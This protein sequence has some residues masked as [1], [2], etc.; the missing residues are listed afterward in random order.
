LIGRADWNDCLNLN[1]FS[2]D[3]DESFQT[4]PLRTRG[5]TAESVFLAGM[6]VMVG[7]EYARLCHKLGEV[8]EA[9]AI[10][11]AVAKMREAIDT[12]GFDGEWFLRAYDARGKKVGSKE[13]P[14]GKIFVEPQGF[15]VMAGMGIEDGK[16]RKA[17]DA[18]YRYL[19]TL[20]GIK[21]LFPAYTSYHEELGEISSYPP[22]YK[23][24]AGIF[25][26]NNPW[27]MIAEV[28]LG[29]GDR[30]FE[31]YRKICPSF[32]EEM[33]ELH[34]LEPYVYAQVIA[35]DDSPRFGEA[36]NSWLTGAAA[37]N[38]VAF[39]QYILG[40]RPD[41]DGLCIDPCL[42][43][44]MKKVVVQRKFRGVEYHIT[45]ENARS[46][47]YM[48]TVDGEVVSGKCIVP[49]KGKSTVEVYC[50]T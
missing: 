40:I 42:P 37:W 23:E 49:L 44:E 5:D 39:T 9:K 24:N 31:Y 50:R 38:Y 2:R 11:L 26:H 1:S 10:E 14:E 27:I 46:G 41:F 22:G 12:H 6:F 45:I 25:C 43:P 4:C 20:H 21:L 35:G 30:A 34:R 7:S 48:L 8:K 15:C 32:R 47:R 33:S 18:V 13:N 3:P 28:K 17:L 19:N 29:R 36:K 16:A